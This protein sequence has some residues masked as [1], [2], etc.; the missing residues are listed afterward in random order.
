MVVASGKLVT[1]ADVAWALCMG[2]DFTATARGFMFALGCIQSLQ[3][4]L[5]TCPTGVTTHNHRLQKGL[6]VPSKAKRVATYAKS[7]NE[8]IDMIAHSCGL[9]NAREFRREHLRVVQHAGNSVPLNEL[10]PY[11]LPA[12]Q[13]RDKIA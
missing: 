8:E 13:R 4:H 6:V 7:I 2:A 11:P 10:Y 12:V 3:C 1:S 9:A 5:D